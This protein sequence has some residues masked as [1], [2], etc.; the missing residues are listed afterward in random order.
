M[1]NKKEKDFFL[2]A[3]ALTMIKVE[4]WEKQ[5]IKNVEKGEI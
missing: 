2:K 4:L 5:Q 1:S 3:Y